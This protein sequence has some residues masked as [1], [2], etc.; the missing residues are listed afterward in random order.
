[1]NCQEITKFIEKVF[2]QKELIFGVS[3]SSLPESIALVDEIK[4]TAEKCSPYSLNILKRVN[5]SNKLDLSYVGDFYDGWALA[6]KGGMKV[7]V[8]TKGDFLL[9]QDGK[10]LEFTA[11]DRFSEGLAAVRVDG[12]LRYLKLD[13]TLLPNEYTPMHGDLEYLR[14]S[15]GFAPIV[16]NR[17]TDQKLYLRRDGT[18]MLMP[19]SMIS[20]GHFGKEGYAL[21]YFKDASYQFMSPLGLILEAQNGST[22][23]RSAAAFSDGYAPVKTSEGWSFMDRRGKFRKGKSGKELVL[24]DRNI[25]GIGSQRD[26]W[27]WVRVEEDKQKFVNLDG[28]YFVDEFGRDKFDAA[29]S[30]SEGF[31]LIY[32]DN[33][34]GKGVKHSFVDVNGK[35]LRGK[36]GKILEFDHAREF[37][38]GLI[39]V[40]DELSSAK[41]IDHNG[42]EINFGKQ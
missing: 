21:I 24:T 25:D 2:T 38:D 17:G 39:R 20:L 5:L 35:Y 6:K 1:M 23:F 36:D 11:A 42:R 34:D 18:E 8:N 19:D 9:G 26:G 15:E 22:R 30:F 29:S 10:P 37:D 4:D 7:F 33:P 27:F 40:R 32:T 3:L 13:G 28:D 12:K 16:P 31:A 14:F 41:Y